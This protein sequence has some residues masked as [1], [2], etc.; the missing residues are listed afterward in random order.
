MKTPP[1]SEHTD[2]YIECR[3]DIMRICRDY[4]LETKCGNALVPSM[5]IDI[6]HQIQLNDQAI[7]LQL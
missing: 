7:A 1:M 6:T 2:L 5:L 3:D 4:Q